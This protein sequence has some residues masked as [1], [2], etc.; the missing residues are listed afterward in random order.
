MP[1]VY[2]AFD[3]AVE[4]AGD[5]GLVVPGHDPRVIEG[6]GAKG[7]GVERRCRLALTGAGIRSCDAGFWSS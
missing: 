5:D 4:L 1:D 7:T 6:A 3:R 2:A